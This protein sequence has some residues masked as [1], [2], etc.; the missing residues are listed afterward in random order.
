MRWHRPTWL[1]PWRKWAHPL[2]L[3]ILGLTLAF[4]WF[5]IC[6]DQGLITWR[7]LAATHDALLAQETQLAERLQELE[8]AA[9]RFEEPKMLE[10]IIRRE[11][12]LVR[13]DETV[14]QFP[15]Q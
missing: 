14:F 9:K 3:A 8:A 13:P 4:A 12:G 2:P 1:P 15:E 6:G 10:P 11:L 7:G 5:I